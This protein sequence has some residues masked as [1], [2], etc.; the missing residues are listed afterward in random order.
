MQPFLLGQLHLAGEGVQVAH[1]ALQDLAQ[2]R[3]GRI[4][5]GRHGLRRDFRFVGRDVV[6]LVFPWWL[7]GDWLS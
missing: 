6:H 3:V 5:E 1:Q 7:R 4:G 2:A